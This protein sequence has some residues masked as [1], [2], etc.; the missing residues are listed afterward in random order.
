MFE[1]GPGL[2]GH[3]WLEV[4]LVLPGRQGRPIEKGH[5]LIEE[6]DIAGDFKVVDDR[7]R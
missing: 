3:L 4:G 5:A 1:Q 2:C 6:P 7:I